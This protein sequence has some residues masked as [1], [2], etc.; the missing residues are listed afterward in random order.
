[1]LKISVFGAGES[2]GD[3]KIVL[4][5]IKLSIFIYV[6]ILIKSYDNTDFMAA[7]LTL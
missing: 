3:I 1:M 7:I 2:N 6:S 4:R 5:S